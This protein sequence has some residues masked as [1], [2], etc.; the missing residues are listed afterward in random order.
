MTRAYARLPLTSRALALKQRSGS[1]KKM[2]A[3]ALPLWD[4]CA[5]Q[6]WACAGTITRAF[7]AIA[8]VFWFVCGRVWACSVDCGRTQGVS[9]AQRR[10]LKARAANSI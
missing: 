5:K 10:M 9:A 8:W 4:C 6:A 2:R 3:R 1:A 7:G